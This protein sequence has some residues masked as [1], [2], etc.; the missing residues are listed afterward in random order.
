M[1]SLDMSSNACSSTPVT[2][3][4]MDRSWKTMQAFF[5]WMPLWSEV[6]ESYFCPLSLSCAWEIS[7]HPWLWAILQAYLPSADLVDY[8]A[9]F[10]SSSHYYHY[11]KVSAH[12]D[13]DHW[14]AHTLVPHVLECSLYTLDCISS[15]LLMKPLVGQ[16]QWESLVGE[17]IQ[18]VV[19]STRK[20]GLKYGSGSS[21]LT[22]A[23]SGDNHSRS[24]D[25]VVPL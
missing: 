12:Q 7:W 5:P 23:H 2:F 4:V 10:C 11:P 17:F 21:W 6:S 8:G 9:T 16:K 22:W 1:Q 3:W 14:M 25:G 24:V 19:K 20:A 18:Q 15:Q 13:Q